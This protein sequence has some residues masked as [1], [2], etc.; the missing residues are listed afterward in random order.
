MAAVRP[1]AAPGEAGQPASTPAT[2]AAARAALVARHA[3]PQL[4]AAAIERAVFSVADAHE[5][6][7][8]TVYPVARMLELLEEHFDPTA[9]VRGTGVGFFS[10]F[11]TP[12]KP[13]R[14]SRLARAQG[15][16]DGNLALKYGQ[17]GA[18]L[19]HN[20]ATQYKFVLQSLTLWRRIMKRMFELWRCADGDLLNDHAYYRLSNTGQGM[21]RVRACVCM[22]GVEHLAHPS[23]AATNPCG[24]QV[25][26]CPAVARTMSDI[27][28]QTHAEVRGW[29]G[30]SVVHLGDRDVP[31][32]LVFIDKYTQVPRILGP[33]GRNR[34]VP[35][36]P[37]LLTRDQTSASGGPARRDCCRPCCARVH[38]AHVRQR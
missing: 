30:L 5:Y 19:E 17:G 13:S 11:F 12:L 23:S 36:R 38:Q 8:A 2:R 6:L 4:S 20:H 27:L 7:A 35:D 37:N 18:K 28:T 14:Y 25:Q 9:P 32:A 16:G 33:I 21:H 3:T 24:F 15:P 10:P 1:D 34:V 29:V 22:R 31:N 26:S